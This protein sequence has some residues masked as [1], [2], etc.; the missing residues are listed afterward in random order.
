MRDEEK[1]VINNIE[2]FVI[3][4]KDFEKYFNGKEMVS[5]EELFEYYIKKL[6]GF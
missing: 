2:K 6:N 3:S 4:N 5:E 1:N